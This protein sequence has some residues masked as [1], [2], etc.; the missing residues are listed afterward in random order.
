MI[1]LEKYSIL[2]R[3]IVFTVKMEENDPSFSIGDLIPHD[4]K[5]FVIRG[6]ETSM[7]LMSP[8]IRSKYVGFVVKE[9][10]K[11][12]NFMETKEKITE[13]KEIKEAVMEFF[14][15][16]TPRF[17]NSFLIFNEDGSLESVE[18][19]SP[20]SETQ[21]EELLGGK[22]FRVDVDRKKPQRLSLYFR[23]DGLTERL[24]PNP[25]TN[26]AL[27]FMVRGRALCVSGENL[28]KTN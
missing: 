18:I 14:V 10:T 15:N 26:L 7:L 23:V 21:I 28:E 1:F 5:M 16:N 20:I 13:I 8:P 24:K 3:G 11:K 6:I 9:I 19:E 25:L 17:K 2:G 12:E 4:G 27:G 22:S